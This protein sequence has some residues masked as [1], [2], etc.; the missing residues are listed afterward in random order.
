M[1]LTCVSR[2]MSAA[3]PPRAATCAR[4]RACASAMKECVKLHTP[5]SSRS[6]QVS[7]MKCRQSGPRVCSTSAP[8]TKESGVSCT[9]E[10][11]A[12]A[13]GVDCVGAPPPPPACVRCA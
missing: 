2:Y 10:A 12:A 5:P 7:L 9:S 4:A 11:S 8:G 3:L 6:V 1:S 13:A